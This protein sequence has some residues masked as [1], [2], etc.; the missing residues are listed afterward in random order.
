MALKYKQLWRVERVFRDTKS[1][2]KTRPIFHKYDRTIRGH[3]FCSF[4][5]LV[6]R[7]ELER[8]LED[9]GHVFEWEQIKRDLKAMQETEISHQEKTF[10]V[11]SE[12]QGICGKVF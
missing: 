11:R 12:A 7:E 5:A 4:L 8:Q 2:L 10:L 9:T 1:L 3:V 6:L